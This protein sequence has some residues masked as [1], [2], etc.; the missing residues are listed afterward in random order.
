[1]IAGSACEDLNTKFPRFQTAKEMY[2]EIRRI[3]EKSDD[4][5][6]TVRHFVGVIEK[7][8]PTKAALVETELFPI[9]A[10]EF[11]TKKNMGWEYNS[12]EE[13]QW[14]LPER[15]GGQ[16]D[17]RLGMPEKIAN[18]INCLRTEPR[19][20][21]AVIPIPFADEPSSAVDWTNQTQTKCCRELYF[22]IGSDGVLR[23]TGILRMQNANIF[24]KNIHFF[25][26]L[27]N[28]I[29]SELSV[30]VGEYTHFIMHLC[31]DRAAISC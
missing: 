8:S 20:K 21:R 7:M 29:A 30:P 16:G 26:T 2:T 10:L 13:S 17:Y 19:S 12:E 31:H 25:A 9:G 23:A 27:M 14:L 4:K 22:Y 11:Y 28:H 5:D 24:P 15:G 1:M 18:V 6:F 3:S